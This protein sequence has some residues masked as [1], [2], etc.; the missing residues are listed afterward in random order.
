MDGIWVW[1]RV[2]VVRD[3]K[4]FRARLRVNLSG[5]GEGEG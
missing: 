4:G 2:R 1:A 5:G 3:V